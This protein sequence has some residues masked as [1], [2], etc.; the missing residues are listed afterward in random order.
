M[1]AE[2]ILAKHRPL[3]D[4]KRSHWHHLPSSLEV[5]G[6]LC[7]PA[8]A[9]TVSSGRFAGLWYRSHEHRIEQEHCGLVCSPGR[10]EQHLDRSCCM[11]SRLRWLLP[12]E[13]ISFSRLNVKMAAQLYLCVV[14]VVTVG[15]PLILCYEDIVAV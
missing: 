13:S 1:S 6:G 2:H 5:L 11:T 15:A 9:H 8:D 14:Q 7:H 4:L 10:E 3:V 12:V